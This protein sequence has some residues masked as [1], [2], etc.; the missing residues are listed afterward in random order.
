MFKRIAEVSS[1]SFSSF[2]WEP[3]RMQEG[4]YVMLAR[5]CEEKHNEA[6]LGTTVT[7]LETLTKRSANNNSKC[8]AEVSISY[9]DRQK[10][11]L[12]DFSLAVNPHFC[13]FTVFWIK[14][15]L[16]I[17]KTLTTGS[18]RYKC[19]C[20]SNFVFVQH[21][22]QKTGRQVFI[23]TQSE[24]I[25]LLIHPFVLYLAF[26]GCVEDVHRAGLNTIGFGPLV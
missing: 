23:P 11:T 2:A 10:V 4:L 17:W 13:L 9:W 20:L 16:N 21:I 3:I 8:A 26:L 25:K 18:R 15:T 7:Q 5:W 24:F 1:S 6:Q 22:H 19:S 12:V 14:L